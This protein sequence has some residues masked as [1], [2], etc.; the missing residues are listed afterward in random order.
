M[1]ASDVQEEDFSHIIGLGL[2]MWLFLVS[3]ILVSAAIGTHPCQSLQRF[4]LFI[5]P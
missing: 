1:L 4:Y 2:L 3:F 5:L